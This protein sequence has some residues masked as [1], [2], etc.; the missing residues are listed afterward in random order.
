MTF[1]LIK[2]VNDIRNIIKIFLFS[3]VKQ[4]AMTDLD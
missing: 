2:K 4:A 3:M 1:K